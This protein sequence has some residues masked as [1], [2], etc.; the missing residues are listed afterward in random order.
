M[1]DNNTHWLFPP[2][3]DPNGYQYRF[4][5]YQEKPQSDF[6][7]LVYVFRISS[8]NG[9]DGQ[10][11]REWQDLSW[12]DAKSFWDSLVENKEYRKWTPK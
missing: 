12:D 1:D 8:Y 10:L 7:G 9:L 11:F 3:D 5:R 6:G 2:K 4:Q